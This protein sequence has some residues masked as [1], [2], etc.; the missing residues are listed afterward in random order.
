MLKRGERPRER[1]AKTLEATA[2]CAAKVANKIDLVVY[3]CA[4][5]VRQRSKM[6]LISVANMHFMRAVWRS[7]YKGRCSNREKGIFSRIVGGQPQSFGG[8]WII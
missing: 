5:C 2:A 1:S 3:G 6:Q 7:Y 8:D 4:T